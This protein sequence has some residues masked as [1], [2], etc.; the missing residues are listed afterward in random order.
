M[1]GFESGGFIWVLLSGLWWLDG[2]GCFDVSVRQDGSGFGC[3]S[4]DAG[5]PKAPPEG[6][7][8]SLS[9]LAIV[10]PHHAV[11]RTHRTGCNSATMPMI[12]S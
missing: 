6:Y 8:F 3:Q 4:V 11:G 10:A 7:S 9:Y 1:L 12:V 5:A 2:F